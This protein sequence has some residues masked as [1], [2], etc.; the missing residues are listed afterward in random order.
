M[1]IRLSMILLVA[2]GGAAGCVARLL[3]GGAVAAW[4]PRAASSFPLATLGVNVVGCTLAGALLAWL[5]PAAA[6]DHL[7]R[8]LLMT[9]SLGGLTT[10]SAFAVETLDLLDRSPAIGFASMALN[11]LLSLVGAWGGMMVVRAI[12]S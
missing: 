10:F 5:A 9:G 7:A 3:A 8:L 6:A 4:L 11:V 1:T 2:A 12:V